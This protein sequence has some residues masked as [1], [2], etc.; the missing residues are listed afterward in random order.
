VQVAFIVNKF[1]V[2]SEMFIANTASGLVS[3]G[4]QVDVFSLHGEGD[5]ETLN[6]LGRRCGLLAHSHFPPATADVD[7]GAAAR[8]LAAGANAVSVA[9]RQGLAVAASGFD[10][11]RHRRRLLS[12]RPINELVMWNGLVAHDVIH[13]QFGMLAEPIIRHRQAGAFDGA[14]V[15]HFRG[16]DVDPLH[17]R[18]GQRLF[19]EIFAEA[20]AVV[21]N[22]A[23]F[24]DRLLAFGCPPEK[25]HLIDSPVDIDSFPWSAPG[26]PEGRPIRLLTVARLTEK[27]GLPYV[28]EAVAILRASGHDIRYRII[29]DGEDRPQLQADIVRLGLQEVV[30]MPGAAAHEQI[31]HELAEADLFAAPSVTSSTG[32]TDAALNTIKEA[33]LAG[34]PVVSTWH[35]G[36]PELVSDG[37][38]GLLVPERD[39][40]ALAAALER[41]IRNPQ[42]WPVFAQRARDAAVSRYGTDTIARRLLLVYDAAIRQRQSATGHFQAVRR[43]AT[44]EGVA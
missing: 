26:H 1:P 44:A 6:A 7:R 18:R 4:H 41:L 11:R 8:W 42:D 25:L 16:H 15:V 43:R 13:C 27:K 32:E 21:A 30:E 20:D 29:G 31:R 38:N 3:A 34:V 5:P 33:M 19:D 37:E 24:C 12:M 39:S 17:R 2:V 35:G 36:I 14:L 23:H 9:R 40:A 28:L 10:L 22:G